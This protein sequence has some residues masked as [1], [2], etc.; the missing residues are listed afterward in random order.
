MSTIVELSLA[1][2][3][4]ALRYGGP[5]PAERREF[6]NLA[7]TRVRDIPV[8]DPT[9]M[10]PDQIEETVARLEQLAGRVRARKV[11]EQVH[12]FMEAFGGRGVRVQDVMDDVGASKPAVL[13]YLRLLESTGK[14][15]IRD[16]ANPRAN[17]ASARKRYFWVDGMIDYG[18]ITL[19]DDGLVVGVR[20][21]RATNDGP[22]VIHHGTA[23][24]FL[25]GCACG[26]CTYAYEEGIFGEAWSSA[27]RAGGSGFTQ[28]VEYTAYRRYAEQRAFE[29][30]VA[31]A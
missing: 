21:H 31:A 7:M 16:E 9:R 15:V 25:Q 26:G 22:G 14:V 20:D 28:G 29:R 24:G 1:A 5:V 18:P 4:R 23:C 17:G 6:E 13:R 10:R 11:Q 12:D 2:H 8:F 27:R 3:E 30:S 19:D